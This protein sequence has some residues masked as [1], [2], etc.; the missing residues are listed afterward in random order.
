MTK[1]LRFLMCESLKLYNELFIFEICEK[2]RYLSQ[3]ML[4]EL[5]EVTEN[6]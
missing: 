6:Q 5:T 4:N 2:Q 3:L 1:M